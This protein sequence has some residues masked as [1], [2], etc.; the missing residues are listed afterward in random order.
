MKN[1]LLIVLIILALTSCYHAMRRNSFS[2]EGSNLRRHRYQKEFMAGERPIKW[3]DQ[4]NFENMP[5]DERGGRIRREQRDF[6]DYG[7]DNG[8]LQN[9][10]F[11]QEYRNFGND[12]RNRFNVPINGDEEDP[13][14]GYNNMN[15]GAPNMNPNRNPNRR[16]FGFGRKYGFGLRFG[17]GR[18][19][20]QFR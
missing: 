18:R 7:R 14:A 16:R 17:M 3:D 20:K 1:S 19:R 15:N 5:E 11:Q 10:G 2:D 9:Q 4:E 12:M 6:F 13:F 8:L